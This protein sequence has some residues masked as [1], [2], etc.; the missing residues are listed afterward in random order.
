MMVWASKTLLKAR[1]A[2]A[3]FY[4]SASTP[5][6]HA[7]QSSANSRKNPSFSTG[8]GF[9]PTPIAKL[10]AQ[11]FRCFY[12]GLP[13]KKL[14]YGWDAAKSPKKCLKAPSPTNFFARR[15]R[16]GLRAVTAKHKSCPSV[17]KV[18]AQQAETVGAVDRQNARHV[19][20]EKA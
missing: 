18:M 11:K 5:I 8:C 12:K 20:R 15:V 10:V 16:F 19:A 9:R 14:S 2:P 13:Y 7:T 4:C 3:E 1:S 6:E 17:A